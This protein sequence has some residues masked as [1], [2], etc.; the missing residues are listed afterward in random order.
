MAII[1]SITIPSAPCGYHKAL[2]GEFSFADNQVVITIGSWYTRET[3]ELGQGMLWSWSMPLSVEQAGDAENALVRDTEGEFYGGFVE[4]QTEV[5]TL[6]S[7]V[8]RRWN[9]I[10]QEK[11]RRETGL[12]TVDARVYQCNE[13]KMLGATV[14]A[15]M[16]IDAGKEDYRQFWVLADNSDV[17]LTAAEMVAVGLAAKNYISSLSEITQALRASL[18]LAES[19]EEV[20]AVIWPE[21]DPAAL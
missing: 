9:E 15:S 7:L 3:Y 20:A 13:L 2:D 12:F 21:P 6:E 17:L 19:P 16:A 18:D 4:V 11:I 8:T 14:G 1:K 5:I 10:K